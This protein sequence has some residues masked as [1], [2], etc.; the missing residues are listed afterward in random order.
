METPTTTE[1]TEQTIDKESLFPERNPEEVQAYHKIKR[2]IHLSH[3]LLSLVYWSIWCF[4]AA[5]FVDAIG[6]ESRWLGLLISAVTMLGGLV[7]VS[8][9][10]DYYSDYIVEKRYDLTNQTPKTWFIFQLK[11]WMVGAVIGGIVLGGLYAALWYSGPLWSLW[12][13]I[14]VML[15]S[16]GLAKI[17]PLIILPLF[18]PAKPLDRPSLTERLKEMAG[19]AGMTITGIFN[20]ALSKETKKA[21]AM[22]AGLGSSR[23]VYLSD[24]LLEAFEDDHIAVVFAHELGH[25]I[26]KHILKGIAMAAIVSS[27]LVGLIHWQLNPLAGSEALWTKAVANF[28]TVML[29][30]TIFPLVSGPITNAISRYFERQA[31]SDALRLTDNPNAFRETFELLTRMNLADPNPPLWEVIM[32]EDHPPMA[33]RIAMADKYT[34]QKDGDT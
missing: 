17:F 2:V 1:Q 20:L 23:R 32:F 14:G 34:P 15:L 4:V 33:Q 21:N 25:H 30:M 6:I 19:G 31:D 18:Y 24:T 26:R 8:L 7:V 12:V 29:I 27:L 28:S 9:P 3:I 16:V 13:W 10:L 22:L 5:D 11:S